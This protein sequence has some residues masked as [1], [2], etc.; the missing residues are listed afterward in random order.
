MVRRGSTAWSLVLALAGAPASAA[1]QEL[2]TGGAVTIAA[3]EVRE[4][5]LYTAGEAVRVAGRLSGDLAAASRRIRVDGQVGG[6][7]FA[8]AST[9]DLR[10]PI[11]DSTRVF[12]QRLDVDAP[13]DGDLMAVVEELVLTGNARIAGRVVAAASLVEIDGTVGNGARIA[14]GDVVV[15]GTVHGDANVRADRL[16]LAPGARI[17]GDLEYRGRTPL[18]PEA[19]AR[20]DGAVRYA[21]PPRERGERRRTWGVLLWFWRML[22][23]LLT[24]VVA[25]RLFRPAVQRLAAAIAEQ[26]T[27]GALLG[28]AAFLLVP[29]AAA[30]AMATLVGLPIG[31]AAALLFGLALYAAKLPAAVWIGDRLLGLAGRPGASPYAAMALG[32]VLL[33]LLFAVP[34]VGGLF[35][36]AATWLGLGAMVV[37]GRRY[38]DLRGG[39]AQQSAP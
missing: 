30:I 37:A 33:Y 16:D 4:G 38:L 27:L 5:D 1:A 14:G 39:A 2:Q 20:V 24:G 34:W 36:L 23:A 21:P 13:I 8:A 26:T 35:W 28:F 12:A 15:R 7:L 11:G 25:V 22:A 17:T 29:V 32:V 10:G 19:A 18:G 6:D 9:V 3:G 31:L